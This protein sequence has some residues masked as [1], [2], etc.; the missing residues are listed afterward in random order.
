M[1]SCSDRA[2]F[3]FFS[4]GYYTPKLRM[5]ILHFVQDDRGGVQDNKGMVQDDKGVVQDERGMVQDN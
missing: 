3:D 2:F 1:I 4:T 5:E